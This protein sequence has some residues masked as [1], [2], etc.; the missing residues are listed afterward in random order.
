MPT[1]TVNQQMLERLERIDTNT[2]AIRET[3]A[4][5][6][7][8]LANVKTTTAK[9]EKAV[10]G[11]GSP[12]LKEI[13]SLHEQRLECVEEAIATVGD[14]PEKLKSIE[15]ALETAKEDRAKIEAERAHIEDENRHAKIVDKQDFRKFWYGIVAAIAAA[16]ISIITQIVLHN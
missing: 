8:D 2:Q 16:M 14:M 10:Y 15:A 7:S 11:N 1:A 9:L 4:G 3:V 5:I 13:T 6:Q 12:G